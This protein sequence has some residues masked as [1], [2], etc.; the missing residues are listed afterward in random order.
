MNFTIAAQWL[1]I[2]A[3]ISAGIQGIKRYPFIT[4]LLNR[5]LGGYVAP[6]LLA[7][8]AIAQGFI[9]YSGDGTLTAGEIVQIAV[10]TAGAFIGHNVAKALPEVKG[11]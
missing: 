9:L 2:A 5:F 8:A 3:S 11:K 10:T 4:G 1:A 6:I 7:V